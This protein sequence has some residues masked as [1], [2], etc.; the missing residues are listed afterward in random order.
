MNTHNRPA[1]P[2][3]LYRGEWPTWMLIGLVY[4]GWTAILGGF[5]LGWLNLPSTTVLLVIWVAWF[6]SMQHELIHGHPTRRPWLNALLGQAPLSIWY[7]YGLYRDS[8][9]LHHSD[10]DLTLPDI[11]PESTYV[12]PARWNR[13][14]PVMRG[15]LTARKTLLGRLLLGPPWGVIVL[16]AGTCRDFTQ[17]DWRRLPL[18]LG[19]GALCAIL[20]Y[21]I[22]RIAGLPAGYYLLAVTWPALSLASVRSFYEH[23]ASAD[24]AERTVINEGG[25][26]T[27]LLFLN[28]NLHA[29]H[30]ARPDV[31]WY[32]LPAFYRS[33]REAL[34]AGNGRFHLTGGYWQ[35]LRRYAV[36]PVDAPAHPAAS[37]SIGGSAPVSFVSSTHG[38]MPFRVAY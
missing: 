15:L 20:L 7:P 31:P 21:G 11:D 27:R 37:N 5:R 17:G 23:R 34:L 16:L 6:M 2:S 19:H 35:L 36:R 28:N 12:S 4:G 24:I 1:H 38:P 32:A 10:S 22:E 30:H 3:L 33:R 29:A 25:W 9:L 26:F 14:G 18:W 13:A 8:H